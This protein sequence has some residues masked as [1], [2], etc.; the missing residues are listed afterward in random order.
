MLKGL[1]NT[2][3]KINNNAV[4]NCCN[5][6]GAITFQHKLYADFELEPF[7][8]YQWIKKFENAEDGF[9]M[10]CGHFQRFS[11]LTREELN[12]YLSIMSDKSKTNQNIISNSSV[13]KGE[14][15]RINILKEL[16]SQ[17][18][19]GTHIER[20]YMARPSSFEMIRVAKDIYGPKCISVSENNETI[21]SEIKKRFDGNKWLQLTNEFQVHGATDFPQG[22]DLYI[23]THC[24]QHS[25][26]LKS[27]LE[28]LKRQVKSGAKVLLLDEV[29]RKIHNPF[30]VNHMSEFF[31]IRELRNK[32]LSTSLIQDITTDTDETISGLQSSRKYTGIFI[33]GESYC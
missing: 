10:T 24:L 6:V 29:Q 13:Y 18:L 28:K 17:K 20:I 16:E 12:E 15:E 4:C 31:L 33:D 26:N 7:A 3:W 9:C 23:I 8:K 11:S 19:E 5:Q 32:G 14:N 27:D 30:H 22:Y 2:K 1:V 21:K 25:I